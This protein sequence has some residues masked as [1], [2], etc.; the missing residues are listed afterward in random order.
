MLEAV[1]FDLDDT[2]L[3]TSALAR[4]RRQGQWSVVKARLPR[5]R[6]FA[7]S[8]VAIEDL[9]ARLKAEGLKIGVLTHSPTWYAKTLLD[10]FGIRT[11]ALITGSDGY[12]PKPDPTSLKAIAEELGVAIG[13][14]V[15][16]R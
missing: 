9:P 10:R 7:S 4:A 15:S 8:D 14:C 16:R 6:P 3:D 13:N 11:D 2:L 1:I 5:V 12:P